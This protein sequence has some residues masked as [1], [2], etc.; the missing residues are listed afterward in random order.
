MSE[1]SGIVIGPQ[2]PSG[3][4]IWLHGLGASGD[5]FAPV[6]PLME[7]PD[8]QFVLPHAPVRPVTINGGVAMRAWYDI[9][10]MEP[11]PGREPEGD[12]RETASMLTSLVRAE[13]ASGVPAS[14]STSAPCQPAAAAR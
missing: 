10:R 3:V 14:S 7:R 4:V 2:R 5:D 13:I 8:L 9:T 6:V 12:I 11:G 1:L